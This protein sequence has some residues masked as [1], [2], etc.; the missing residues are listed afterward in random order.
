MGPTVRQQ[1]QEAYGPVPR[2]PALQAVRAAQEPRLDFKFDFKLEFPAPPGADALSPFS[3]SSPL[4]LKL[5]RPDILKPMQMGH[6]L[7]L[8]WILTRE[9]GCSF[10]DEEEVIR[11]E[12]QQSPSFNNGKVGPQWKAG[13]AWHVGRGGH[14]Q[15]NYFRRCH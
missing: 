5:I 1:L 8:K 2:P 10:E 3:S 11:Y 14:G 4:V 13:S 7:T 12:I 15:V 6:P 9:Q